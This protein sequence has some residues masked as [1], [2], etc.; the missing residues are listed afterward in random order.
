MSGYL[1][2]SCDLL[3]TEIIVNFDYNLF[4]TQRNAWNELKPNNY[5]F[6]LFKDGNGFFV[7]IDALIIVE[8][9]QYKE[10]FSNIEYGGTT[11]YNYQT[12]DNIYETIENIYKEYNNTQ[13]SKNEVYLEKIKVEYD[14][15]NNIPIKIEYFYYVPAIVADAGEYWVY[16]ITEYKNND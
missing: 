3:K 6:N 4:L 5:Q 7:P 1:L 8:N 2:I 9:G 10:E 12:I 13:R 16:K 15:E 14:L 11:S